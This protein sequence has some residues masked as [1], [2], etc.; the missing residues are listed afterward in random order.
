MVPYY[1]I[2]YSDIVV[3]FCGTNVSYCINTPLYYAIQ[4]S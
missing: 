1:D 2:S 3:L 4:E